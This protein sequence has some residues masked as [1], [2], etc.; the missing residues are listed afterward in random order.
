MTE[1]LYTL[2]EAQRQLDRAQCMTTGHDFDVIADMSGQPARV[3]CGRCGDSWA[4]Q[5][6]D[7]P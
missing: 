2:A 7:T 1:R 4:V 6:R 3:A 5:P